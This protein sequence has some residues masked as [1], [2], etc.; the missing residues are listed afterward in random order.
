V[1]E[2]A[3]GAAASVVAAKAHGKQAVEPL[4]Q[5]DGRPLRAMISQQ[6]AHSGLSHERYLVMLSVAGA[7]AAAAESALA[8]AVVAMVLVV[9]KVVSHGQV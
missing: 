5:G 9:M 8:G 1:K 7:V 2:V 6:A 3:T 4:A